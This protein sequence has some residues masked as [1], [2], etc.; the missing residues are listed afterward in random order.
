MLQASCGH[1]ALLEIPWL[2]P[3]RPRH[4]AP[5]TAADLN[6]VQDFM[7][8]HQFKRDEQTDENVIR[9]MFLLLLLFF[10]I[11]QKLLKEE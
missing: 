3:I 7:D 11:I 10:A 5:E 2:Q 6:A 8:N 1:T 9:I 4:V